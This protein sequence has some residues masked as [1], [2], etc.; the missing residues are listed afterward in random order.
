MIKVLME[1]DRVVRVL[2]PLL[3]AAKP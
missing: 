2:Y 1:R 3:A